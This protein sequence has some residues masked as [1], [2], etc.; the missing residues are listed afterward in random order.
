MQQLMRTMGLVPFLLINGFLLALAAVAIVAGLH[1]RRRAAL[2][3][4]T[5]TAN[6]GMAEDGYREFEG[7][8]EAIPGA[9]LIAPL[10]QSPCAW[11]HAKL[12]KWGRGSGDRESRWRTIKESTSAA[13]IR[14]RDSTGVCLVLPFLAEVTPTDKSQW[15]GASAEPADR[16]PPRLGPM[17]S[18]TSVI[19]VSGGANSH[20]RYSEERIYVGDPLL[21]LGEFSRRQFEPLDEE[22]DEDEEFENGDAEPSSAG[23]PSDDSDDTDDGDDGGSYDWDELVRSREVTRLAEETTRACIQKGSTGK[24]FIMSTTKQ[25]TH[26][27]VNEVGSQ[28]ALYMAIAPLSLVALLFYARFG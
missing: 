11:Y 8:I 5:P 25:D 14:L 15:T 24:P 4:A 12:E 27:Y 10:T 23:E 13:P 3:K 26:V 2:I 9:Q 6:I 19:T 20:F 22:E 18:T 7:T 1:G 21:V 17:E 28:A 16:H